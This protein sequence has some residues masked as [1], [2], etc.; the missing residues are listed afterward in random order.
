LGWHTLQLS[1]EAY[2]DVCTNFGFK[3]ED[4]VRSDHHVTNVKELIAI[5]ISCQALT[6]TACAVHLIGVLRSGG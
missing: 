6:R 4:T 2:V 5:F 3:G 1:R